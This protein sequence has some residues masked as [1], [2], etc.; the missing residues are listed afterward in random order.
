M[1]KWEQRKVQEAEHLSEPGGFNTS[2]L[3]HTHASV[4]PNLP[5]EVGVVSLDRNHRNSWW[6]PCLVPL[7][8]TDWCPL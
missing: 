3:T 7:D 8:P 6:Q 5:T 2:P 4:F 1:R